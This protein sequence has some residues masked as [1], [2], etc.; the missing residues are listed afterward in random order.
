V[1]DDGDDG[2]VQSQRNH[3]ADVFLTE[4]LQIINDTSL[5]NCL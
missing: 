2:P 4:S 5:V 3:A 1:K